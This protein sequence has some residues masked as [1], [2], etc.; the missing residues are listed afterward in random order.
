VGFGRLWCDDLTIRPKALA[1]RVVD[2][3]MIVIGMDEYTLPS[4]NWVDVRSFRR[5][6][7]AAF[8]DREA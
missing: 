5:P 3:C 2:V 6:L 1:C 7:E 8:F 4:C